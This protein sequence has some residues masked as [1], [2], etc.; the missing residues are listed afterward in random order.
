M[1]LMDKFQELMILALVEQHMGIARQTHLG[2]LEVLRVKFNQQVAELAI[3]MEIQ[4]VQLLV[5]QV[6]VL[7]YH[8]TLPYICG[9]ERHNYDNRRLF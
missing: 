9:K 2:G 1:H 7:I 3:V 5:I 8:H 4:V 6:P